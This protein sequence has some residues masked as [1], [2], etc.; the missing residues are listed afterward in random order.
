MDASTFTRLRRNRALISNTYTKV[1]GVPSEIVME[2]AVGRQA[3]IQEKKLVQECCNP[4][5]NYYNPFQINFLNGVDWVESTVTLTFGCKGYID[6]SLVDIATANVIS[7]SI[8][9]TFNSPNNTFTYP[10][11]YATSTQR[12]ILRVWLDPDSSPLTDVTVSGATVRRVTS[13]GNF[14]PGVYGSLDVSQCPNLRILAIEGSIN[15]TS[16][17]LGSPKTLLNAVN[18]RGSGITSLNVSGCTSLSLLDVLNCSSLETLTLTGCSL[19]TNL[20]AH[21]CPAL[22]TLT[23]TGCTGLIALNVFKNPLLA[24]IDVSGFSSLKNLYAN[25]CQSLKSINASDCTSLENLIAYSCQL[26]VDV[27][28]A[29]CKPSARIDLGSCGFTNV[30][31]NSKFANYLLVGPNPA[32][33]GLIILSGQGIDLV[34]PSNLRTLHDTYGWTVL[35]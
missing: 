8:I 30:T 29:N 21:D 19:L 34:D 18:A 22:E 26:L 9:F 24:A 6:F 10:I 33:G 25:D 13:S 15:L 32:T 16:V 2:R 4:E 17:N 23:L 12:Y 14:N 1:P 3:F 27:N 31:A 28:A 35:V 7:S 5:N 20:S 11:P